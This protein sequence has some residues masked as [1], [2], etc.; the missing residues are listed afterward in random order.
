[1]SQRPTTKQQAAAKLV[2]VLYVA[3]NLTAIAAF[4]VRGQFIVPRNPEATAAKIAASEA[5]FRSGV[6]IELLTVAGVLVLAASLYFVLR[7]VDR[8]LA[9]SA[10][11]WRVVENIVL[12]S[13][14]LSAVALAILAS[15]GSAGGPGL[16]TSMMTLFARLYG[17]SYQ[18][19]FL[20]LGLGSTMFSYL[21]L[22]SRYIPSAIA[23]WGILSS[24]LLAIGAAALILEPTLSRV[25]G[26]TY[27]LPMGIYEFG[28]GLWLIFTR[29]RADEEKT[30][31]SGSLW[32]L[33]E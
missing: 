10:L 11:L 30:G 33:E 2:G 9:L 13:A 32:S 20:F 22:R 12:A 31:N 3:T 7:P 28:L 27:M 4:W 16:D 14:P 24:L 8:L 25:L 17:V 29:L 21:W 23:I 19:G 18:F 15:A 1:M 26:L 5:F 6:V